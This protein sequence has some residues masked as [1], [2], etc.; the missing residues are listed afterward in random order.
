MIE[1]IKSKYKYQPLRGDFN[2]VKTPIN[3]LGITANS[4]H[5]LNIIYQWIK[6]YPN[7]RQIVRT[8]SGGVSTSRLNFRPPMYDIQMM[9]NGSNLE[10]TVI[11]DNICARF[12]FRAWRD[13]LVGGRVSY[14]RTKGLVKKMLNIDLD[15]YMTPDGP[16]RRDEVESY[17]IGFDSDYM[18]NYLVGDELLYEMFPD[19][20][21]ARTLYGRVH[22][23][24]FHSSFAGGI[25]HYYPEL[26]PAFEYIYRT[27]NSENDHKSW[28]TSFIGYCWS[29]RY[30]VPFLD[31][32]RDA[33]YDNNERVRKMAQMLKDNGYRILLYNTDGIWYEGDEPFHGPG[34]GKGLGE[35]ENDHVN[36]ERFRVKSKGCYEYI[37]DGIYY[38]VVRGLTRLDRI[39]PREEWEWGDIFNNEAEI[40]HIYWTDEGLVN[41]KGEL[42]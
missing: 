35:W 25:A 24:D 21:N 10:L 15:D 5:E 39:K 28:L 16:E 31:L 34:E 18:E 19:R 23:L 11:A 8:P 38:P 3:A 14:L 9:N 22:H 2:W 20:I 41:E 13:G 6:S 12:Q 29:K 30:G 17:I 40:I 32:A 27:R 42:Y 33:I 26:R 7:I 4:A 36:V 37:E 1:Y